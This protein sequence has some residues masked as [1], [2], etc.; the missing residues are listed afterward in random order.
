MIT[1]HLFIKG[2]NVLAAKSLHVF[3]LFLT[4][5]ISSLFF[6]SCSKEKTEAPKP[7]RGLI[8]DLKSKN[9]DC[10]CD[11]YINE[12]KWRNKNVYVLAYRGPACDWFPSFYDSNGQRFTLDAGYNY[13]T[14]LQ[15]SI[16][17]KNIWTCK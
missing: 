7:I 13:N 15:E 6:Y 3:I 10:T 12:Y 9:H 17:T 16:F 5:I 11:P 4:L 8:L 2:D 1:H 14:F